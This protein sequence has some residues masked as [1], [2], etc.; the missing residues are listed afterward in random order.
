MQEIKEAASM[1][2][3]AKLV[4]MM[5]ITT[6]PNV[7]WKMDLD[8]QIELRERDLFEQ[9]VWNYILELVEKDNRL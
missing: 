8:R 9:K 5:D 7:Y 1:K 4:Y 3:W 2:V 6:D